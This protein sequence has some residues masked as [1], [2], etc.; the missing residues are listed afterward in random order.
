MNHEHTVCSSK[1]ENHA[2]E[3]NQDCSLHLLKQP[4]T[5][6]ATH[7]YKIVKKTHQQSII[8]ADYF[9]LKNHLQLSFSLRGPPSKI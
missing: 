3:K 5:F 9:Y 1:V 8:Y 6:L 7:T 4:N 2:H